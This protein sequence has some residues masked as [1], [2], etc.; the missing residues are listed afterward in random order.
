MTKE[1][2]TTDLI[3]QETIASKIFFI[4]GKKVML[5][6]DLAKLYEVM[7]GNLNKAVKR[8][9]DRFPEDFMFQLTKEEFESLMFQFGISKRGG[10]RSLPYAFTEQGVAMLSSVLNSKRAILVNI[11]II[12]VFTRLREM[13][14][15]NADIRK[16]IEDLER[17]TT[18]KLKEHDEQL[19]MVF[20]ALK[21]LL[22][23]PEEPKEQIGFKSE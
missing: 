3:P 12:R 13:L 6:R 4:R 11:R 17:K 16:K 20:E 21:Q 2:N 14:A 18:G 5:D 8:N 15:T 7:T 9:I 10:T 23:P 19:A 22:Q 1:K